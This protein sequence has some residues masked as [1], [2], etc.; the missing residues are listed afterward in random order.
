LHLKEL[1]MDA[2]AIPQ[3]TPEA[4]MGLFH[5]LSKEARQIEELP[6]YVVPDTELEMGASLG[7]SSCW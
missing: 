2:T 1:A 6:S 3:E 4:T 5:A 7:N